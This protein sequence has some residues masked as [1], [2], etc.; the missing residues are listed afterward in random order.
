MHRT[1]ATRIKR[2]ANA[3]GAV[4]APLGRLIDFAA[5]AECSGNDRG[6]IEVEGVAAL[7]RPHAHSLGSPTST[8]ASK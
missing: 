3:L 8:L 7:V 5:D 4:S 2:L 6:F 1:A